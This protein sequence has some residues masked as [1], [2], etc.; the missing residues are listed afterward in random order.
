[1]IRQEECVAEPASEVG[2]PGRDLERLGSGAEQSGDS[3]VL[4]RLGGAGQHGIDPRPLEPGRHGVMQG[5]GLVEEAQCAVGVEADHGHLGRH[6]EHRRRL[7][8][9]S[10]Q[11]GVP[12]HRQ[13]VR[14]S[15]RSQRPRRRAM[16]E[17]G[18]RSPD[19][20]RQRLADEGMGEDEHRA[21]F[22]EKVPV[23]PDLEMVEQLTRAGFGDRSQKVQ[24]D[25]RPDHRRGAQRGAGRTGSATALFDGVADAGRKLTLVLDGGQFHQ[26]EGVAPA[27][28]VQGDGAVRADD[29]GHGIEI[30]WGQCDGGH[31]GKGHALLGPPGRHDEDRAVD[32]VPRRVGE[33]AQGG[34]VG[35][36]HVVE[37]QHQSLSFGQPAQ[38]ASER[39][40]Q[41]CLPG[42]GIGQRGQ[43]GGAGGLGLE[44][45]HRPQDRS[46][47]PQRDAGITIGEMV[48]ELTDHVEHRLEGEGL[49]EFV[50]GDA[51]DAHVVGFE[52]G[53]PHIE[54]SRFA[55]PGRAFDHGDRG[56]TVGGAVEQALQFAQRL[57]SSGEI[58]GCNSRGRGRSRAGRVPAAQDRCVERF[59]LGRRVDAERFGQALPSL[60][61]GR[62]RGRRP[63]GSVQRLHQAS[64]GD[65]VE[66]IPVQQ[67]AGQRNGVGPVSGAQGRG[68]TGVA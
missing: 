15:P 51:H 64:E 67:E 32:Q 68:S 17:G 62:Q 43:L 56:L 35:Q 9:F 63:A 13:R 31:I 11:A 39:A 50:A 26:E 10:A 61:V 28:L 34:R 5:D 42:V 59:C 27:P 19:G 3:D 46:L 45:D 30:E 4:V 12:S 18:A 60:G 53:G 40:E 66:R 36:M 65:L 33:P 49:A 48:R 1:M 58:R 44:P 41:Q 21:V 16:D 8:Q 57:S 52:M 23:Q 14:V 22:D 20:R 25:V 38:D 24:V 2:R 7:F 6:Q 37:H 55:D 54:Q 29:T 47:E